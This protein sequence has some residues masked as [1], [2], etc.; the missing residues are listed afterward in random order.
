M[1]Q[2]QSQNSQISMIPFENLLDEAQKL[3]GEH[4][5]LIV[6]IDKT[7]HITS[8]LNY[9]DIGSIEFEQIVAYLL[10]LKMNYEINKTKSG[11]E[12]SNSEANKTNETDAINETNEVK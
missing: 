11:P 9:T 7:K 5:T 1:N 10:E 8:L 6:F 4:P 3:N 2:F 12:E